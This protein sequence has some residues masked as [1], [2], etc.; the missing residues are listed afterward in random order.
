[1]FEDYAARARKRGP[2]AVE[3]TAI[4][5]ESLG[6]RH[7]LAYMA[8]GG[9]STL[10]DIR[11]ALHSPTPRL[12]D[13]LWGASLG[14]VLGLHDVEDTDRADA[15]ALLSQTADR[16]PDERAARPYRALYAELLFATGD[17]AAY[18]RRIGR[19][20]YLRG[21]D[22]KYL[23][24]DLANPFIQSPTADRAT[25]EKRFALP[26]T[27]AG[28]EIPVVSD[29]H[30]G[31]PLDRLTTSAVAGSVDGPLVTVIL[32]TFKPARAALLASARSILE[33]TWRTIELLVVDDASPD[34]FSPVLDEVAQMDRRVRVIRLPKNGGT[35]IARN[36]GID[37]AQG[38]F[39]TCQ[40]ADDWSH[41]RR[42]EL[43]MAPLIADPSLPATRSFALNVME[44]LVFQ[45]PGYRPRRSNASSLLFRLQD[46]RAI[47]GFLRMRRAADTEFHMR[48]AAWS[49]KAVLD[50]DQPLALV[51]ILDQSLSRSDFRAGWRHPARR[52]FAA[53]YTHWHQNATRQSLVLGAGETP[54]VRIPDR[55]AV[56]PVAPRTYDVV[57]AGDWRAFGGP[58][59][60]MIEE[61]KALTARGLRIGVLHLE[62]GRFMSRVSKDLC[63]PVQELINSRRVDQVLM[64]DQHT[65]RL[66]ILRYPLILQ[67]VPI[68]PA[69]LTI[70]KIIVLAN[71]APSEND[72]TDVRYHVDEC[73]DNAEVLFGSRALWVPQGPSVRVPLVS[74]VAPGELASFDMMGILDPQEWITERESF[75]A[76]RPVIGRHSRDN[77]M[78]WPGDAETLTKVYPTDG[79]YD[80]RVMG[81]ATA[82]LSVLGVTETPDAWVSFE[83]NELPVRTFLNSLD[84]FV[85]FNHPHTNEAFGRA[86]L[87]GITSGG[88]A[89]LP[90][91]F[92]PTFGAGALYREPHEVG[93]TIDA[94]YADPKLYT[95][96][97]E[98]AAEVVRER[99][100][101]ESYATL[102]EGLLSRPGGL[103]STD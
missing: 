50:I 46:A 91:H 78:K 103:T 101:Y 82:P 18:G 20:S 68:H 29:D 81:G 9:T 58:Q 33:Q 38:E 65:V 3:A 80:V 73:S 79:R 72:G 23:L 92:E 30:H 14:R 32:T 85:N 60:S 53:S 102:V 42:L 21:L 45:R 5:C 11:S 41:P 84:F 100:S 2:Q 49:G 96:Q 1:M 40:D 90:H 76:D 99:F 31:L 75:R 88:V 7:L 44:T 35:Y 57:F 86:T 24:A 27:S 8:S 61:I 74:T 69:A 59:K 83:M 36:V 17:Y 94:L 93:A 77:L 28:L 25:W 10:E 52:A 64:D 16:I 54:P 67:Y 98:I 43:Q 87:E 13:P 89:I 56:D 47:G 51:R 37:E 70:E 95:Q 12:L 19:D 71:Q 4:R 34:D 66:F 15:L 6:Y 26:F 48:L 97:R 63:T 55:F 22:N 39:V 62:A